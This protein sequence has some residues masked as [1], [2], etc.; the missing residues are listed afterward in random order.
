[1]KTLRVALLVL[2]C[3]AILAPA[4]RAQAAARVYETRED[5]L[6][7][8][9]RDHFGDKDYSRIGLYARPGVGGPEFVNLGVLPAGSKFEIVGQ[10]RTGWW[11][12]AKVEF[13]IRL[14]GPAPFDI[15]TRPVRISSAAALHL[16]VKDDASGERRLNPRYFTETPARAPG[17]KPTDHA[18]PPDPS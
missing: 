12:F 16:Y 14:L 18:R 9:V 8:G 11:P 10:A 4:L 15:G 13:V 3:A 7:R 17:G 5:L 1:M 6:V 2:G